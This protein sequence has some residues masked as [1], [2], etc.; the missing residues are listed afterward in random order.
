M[1]GIL[2]SRTKGRHAQPCRPTEASYKLLEQQSCCGRDIGIQKA[3]FTVL[4]A[5]RCIACGYQIRAEVLPHT[6]SSANIL[7]YL[8]AKLTVLLHPA[9]A[10]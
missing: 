3:C 4:Y 10:S 8:C 6:N 7:G 1:K 9:D 2:P 5:A